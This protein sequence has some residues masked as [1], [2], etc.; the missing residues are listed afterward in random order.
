MSD[1]AGAK[2]G[3]KT[4]GKVHPT[5]ASIAWRPCIS[6]ASRAYARSPP[7]SVIVVE[8]PRGSKP[9]SP[10]MEPSSAG[11]FLRKGSAEERSTILTAATG[12]DGVRST[13]AVGANAMDAVAATLRAMTRVN[14]S[15]SRLFPWA[16][17]FTT[18]NN[19]PARRAARAPRSVWWGALGGKVCALS[20]P[21]VASASGRSSRSG[22]GPAASTRPGCS[23]RP[24]C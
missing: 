15:R 13:A 22:A 12:E 14:S 21:F 10:T 2:I 7:S 16:V 20:R 3:P 19:R 4:A 11:G 9:A 1:P 8:K 18:S 24:G 6:S 5:T 17:S 23:S